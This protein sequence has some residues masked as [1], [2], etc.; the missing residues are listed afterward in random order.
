ME[1]TTSN[2]NDERWVDSVMEAIEIL[3]GVAHLSKIYKK[4]FL[5]RTAAGQSQVEAHDETVRQTLQA[6]CSD[7]K[8]YKGG[9]SLFRLLGDRGPG[10]WGLN[11]PEVTK[12]RAERAEAKIFLKELGL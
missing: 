12:R 8:Q 10:Y 4:V 11:M 3:G 5:L 7:C 6:H 9:P 1:S 2:D